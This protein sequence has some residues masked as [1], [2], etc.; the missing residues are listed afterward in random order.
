MFFLSRLGIIGISKKVGTC[1]HAMDRAGTCS[2]G[3][4]AFRDGNS[5]AFDAIPGGLGLQVRPAWRMAILLGYNY[6]T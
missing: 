3:L 5:E 4:R 1:S 6:L 2:V